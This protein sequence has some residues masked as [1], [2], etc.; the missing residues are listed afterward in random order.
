MAL[1]EIL[2]FAGT[3]NGTNLLTQVA[4][5]SDAQRLVGNQ[6][7][8]ARAQLVNKALRQTSIMAAALAKVIAD[9]QTQN[10]TDSL[11][12]PD[13]A[14][15][16]REV[17]ADT[18]ASS[19]GTVTAGS[20]TLGQGSAGLLLIDATAGPITI[21]LPFANQRQGHKINFRRIDS[22]GN[23]VTIQ[24]QG[25]NLINGSPS[26]NLRGFASTVG[27]FSDGNNGWHS[28]LDVATSPNFASSLGVI[29]WKR[30]GDNNSPSG[31]ILLQWGI[32]NFV[33]AGTVVT[34]PVTFPNAVLQV[35]GMHAGAAPNIP[36]PFC[37]NSGVGTTSQFTGHFGNAGGPFSASWF[38]IGH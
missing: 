20:T 16:L 7:G 12:V 32:A 4:Y 17:L 3:D 35:I 11:G 15:L 36:G 37:V 24:R 14:N 27:V 2:P 8:V 25:G 30:I 31:S 22:T 34:F 23:L 18:G 38:A 10:V 19:F 6:P 29:G 33:Q 9:L 1:N 28:P 26:F 13:M 21:T 5:N